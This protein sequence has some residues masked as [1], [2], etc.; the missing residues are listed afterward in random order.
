MFR[1]P[2]LIAALVLLLFVAAMPAHAQQGTASGESPQAS[3]SG[4]LPQFPEPLTRQ[5]I[6]DVLSGLDDAQVREL[7]VKELDQKV[8]AREAQ[9]ATQEQR[10][11]GQ[12]A[13]QFVDAGSDHDVIDNGE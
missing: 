1:S 8:A 6:R 12:F 4:Q 11:I 9:L 10:S 3:K 2:K 13:A 5:A 7:L